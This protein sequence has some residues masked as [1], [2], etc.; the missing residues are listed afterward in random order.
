METGVL[1]YGAGDT[2]WRTGVWVKW[3]KGRSLRYNGFP[4]HEE[5]D[6]WLRGTEDS[7]V[8]NREGLKKNRDEA[9]LN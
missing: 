4:G 6:M 2:Q 7:N 5:V 8:Q 1:V 9:R 3:R